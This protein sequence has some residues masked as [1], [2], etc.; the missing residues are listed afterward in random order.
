[1][2]KFMFVGSYRPEGVKGL[3]KEGASSRRDTIRKLTES[4]GGTLDAFYYTYGDHDVYVFADL[5]DAT[6]A[7]AFSLA[8]NATGAVKLTTLPLLT[9]EELDAACRKTVG[10]RAPG[11]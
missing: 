11:A 4:L 9:P 2:A 1:M 7:L 5:P 8:V 3:I 6:T 10:Y